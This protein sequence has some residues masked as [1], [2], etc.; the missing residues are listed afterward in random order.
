VT[1]AAA[2]RAT[3]SATSPGYVPGIC[4]IGPVEIA[5]RRRVGHA[6]AVAAVAVLAGLVA[7]DAPAPTRL[8]VAL[9]AAAAASGY[10]QAWLRFCAAF[11]SRGIV[12]F[13]ELGERQAIADPAA[14]ARD[15]AMSRRIGAASL[16]FGVVIAAAAVALPV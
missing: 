5:R 6:G 12:N 16:A 13:G 10:L 4:N 11:G 9:P 2:Q 14:R 1:I 3:E 15:R 7:I 8:I